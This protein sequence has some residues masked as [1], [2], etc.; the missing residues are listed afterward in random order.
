M[1]NSKRGGRL[2]NSKYVTRQKTERDEIKAPRARG[3]RS[4][5]EL[6][7]RESDTDGG[8]GN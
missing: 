1:I 4:R 3:I 8:G 2:S 5:G 7:E 6:R